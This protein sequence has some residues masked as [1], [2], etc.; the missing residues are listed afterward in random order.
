MAG[1][2]QNQRQRFFTPHYSRLD[3]S[4][5]RISPLSA[6]DA[7]C[8]EERPGKRGIFEG[9]SVGGFVRY[10]QWTQKLKVLA[11]PVGAYS[12]WLPEAA[13]WMAKQVHH[14]MAPH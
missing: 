14:A 2:L 5:S 7:R 10:A 4:R 13:V 8:R 1:L 9:K 12:D 6:A 11:H 3:R